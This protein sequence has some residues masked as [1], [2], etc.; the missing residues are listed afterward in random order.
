MK[1]F[2]NQKEKLNLGTAQRKY[3]DRVA[4][5]REKKKKKISGCLTTVVVK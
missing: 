4:E 2:F 5:R 1:Q 3:L